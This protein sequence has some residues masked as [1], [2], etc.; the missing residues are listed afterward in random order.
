MGQ[1]QLLFIVLGLV[2]I[3]I[4]VI[5]GINYFTS[6][7]GKENREAIIADLKDIAIMA[8]KYYREP[9]TLNGG[10][11]AFTGWT[12]PANLS[13][14]ANMSATVTYTIAAQ[15]VILVGVGKEKGND[16]TTVVKVT[17][18]VGPTE[19]ISTTINN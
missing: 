15:S 5:V 14:T 1:Q 19:I 6:T 4:A 2:I 10:G 13:L 18:L 7:S 9:I 8:Q 16:G 12:V 3:G 11:R 17:M